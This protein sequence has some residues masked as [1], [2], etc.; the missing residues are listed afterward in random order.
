MDIPVLLEIVQTAPSV[1]LIVL[2]IWVWQM[3]KKQS[4]GIKEFHNFKEEVYRDFVSVEYLKDFKED[5]DKRLDSIDK[6]LDDIWRFRGRTNS[7]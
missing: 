5:I 7:T 4:E 6:K 1:I 3:W 2:A